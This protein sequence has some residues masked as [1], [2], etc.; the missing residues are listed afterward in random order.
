MAPWVE[1]EAVEQDV[2]QT[3]ERIR[4]ARKETDLVVIH[5]HWG[6]PNGWC[7]AFQGPLADYQRSLGHALI[8]AGADLL[9]GHHPHVVH[10]VERYK[11][12]LIAYSLGHFLFHSM[13][14]DRETKLTHSYPP[15]DVSS[16]ETGAARQTVILEL[17]VARDRMT[18]V[19]FRPVQMNAQG[20][21]E[22]ARGAE[23]EGVLGRLAEHSSRMG[24]KV[25]IRGHVAYVAM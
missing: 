19:S 9:V 2:R 14:E 11:E 5:I 1:T 16:L 25:E 22:F 24:T 17:E 8:D 13:S 15:Y 20:E 10:G 6:I 4:S 7:A 21:P 23:A 3:C 18:S 12:G